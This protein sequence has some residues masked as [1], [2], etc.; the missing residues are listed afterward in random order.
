MCVTLPPFRNAGRP[1]A[2]GKTR[3]PRDETYVSAEQNQACTHTRFP[4]PYG[5][6]SR[7]PRVEAPSRQRPRQT[8]APVAHRCRQ[9]PTLGRLLHLQAPESKPA[10]QRRR[11]RSCLQ[12]SH[13]QQGQMVYRTGPG[14]RPRYRPARPRDI[15]KTLPPG[16]RQ[17][18]DKTHRQGVVS[19]APGG[20]E[21]TGRCRHQPAGGRDGQQPAVVRQHGGPLAAMPGRPQR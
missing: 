6:E 19:A 11:V 14:E 2:R 7:A 15:E 9:R 18:S 21:R 5:D 17:K 16:N 8:H 3:Y 10:A 13:A 12:K 1:A 20:F 4:C